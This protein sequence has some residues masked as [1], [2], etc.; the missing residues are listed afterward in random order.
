MS[1]CAWSARKGF[2]VKS[3][4]KQHRQASWCTD[5]KQCSTHLQNLAQLH[6]NY[7]MA[8]IMAAW[9]MFKLYSVSQDALRYIFKMAFVHIWPIKTSLLLSGRLWGQLFHHPKTLNHFIDH[10]SL[11]TLWSH[12][13]KLQPSVRNRFV[14]T[15]HNMVHVEIVLWLVTIFWWAQ[16]ECA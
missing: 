12:G 5:L 14:N 2:W 4:S 16:F 6:V 15:S 10:A 7:S 13:T 9:F 11:C 3:K 1:Q 8:S